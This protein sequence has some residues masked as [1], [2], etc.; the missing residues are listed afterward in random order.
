MANLLLGVSGSIAAYK[1]ADLASKLSQAGHEVHV[2]MSSAARQLVSANTF[3][4][5]TGNHVFTDLWDAGG[6]TQHIALTDQA[7]LA[8]VAPATANTLAKLALGLGD[9]MLSTTLLALDCPLL[10]CPAMNTRMW[11]NPAVQ[12]NLETLRGRGVH[13]LEPNA[14]ALACGHVGAGR[15]AEPVEIQAEVERLLAGLGAAEESSEATPAFGDGFGDVFG[16]GDAPLLPR[17]LGAWRVEEG[18]TCT[19]AHALGSFLRLTLSLGAAESAELTL[20]YDPEGAT[21]MLQQ[22]GPGPVTRACLGQRDEDDDELSFG[23]VC[24]TP[25]PDGSGWDLEIDGALLR[26]RR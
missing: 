8:L 11:N 19:G 22:L 5:L 13:V 15:L 25:T 6:Q 12:Q 16:E 18:G 3:L 21:Y 1:A 20:G 17:L 24:L 4:N 26:L 23:D 14:G 7:E 2:V 9:D 10:V